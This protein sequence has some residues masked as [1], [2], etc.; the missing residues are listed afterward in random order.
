MVA[1]QWIQK[2]KRIF[3]SSYRISTGQ[4]VLDPEAYSEALSEALL[5]LEGDTAEGDV[6][7]GA[8]FWLAGVQGAAGSFS[9]NAGRRVLLARLRTE[10]P[11]VE[12][13]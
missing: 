4:S 9:S 2:S 1:L 8:E 3:G 7:R 6:A 10:L 12:V 11:E 5:N 13:E